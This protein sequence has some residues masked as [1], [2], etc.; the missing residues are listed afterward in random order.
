MSTRPRRCAACGVAPRKGAW[1]KPAS[2]ERR[3]G[4]RRRSPQG[5]VGCSFT[6]AP[7]SGQ[8][9]LPARGAWVET[10]RRI[11][12]TARCRSP[13]KGAWVETCS[14]TTRSDRASVAPARGAWVELRAPVDGARHHRSLP[15]RGAWLETKPWRSRRNNWSLPARSGLKHGAKPPIGTI[16]KSL[17]QAWD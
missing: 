6:L 16:N 2:C 3:A 13:R 14:G 10:A 5:S 4:R 1:V 7:H 12:G 9:S 8:K 17:P 15:A 11:W